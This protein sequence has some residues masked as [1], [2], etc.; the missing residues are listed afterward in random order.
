MKAF[1]GDAIKQAGVSI[2]VDDDAVLEAVPECSAVGESA[3]NGKAERAAQMLEDQVRNR[4]SALEARINARVNAEHPAMRWLVRQ[5]ALIL[6]RFS[7]NPNVQTPYQTLHEKHASDTCVEF[8]TKVYYSVP[9]HMTYKLELRWRLGICI[10][11]SNGTNEYYAALSNGNV[12][13]ARS[14]VRV[15]ASRRCSA[16]SVHEYRRHPRRY[17]CQ[18]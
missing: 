8:G 1:V 3:S 2:L 5:A 14:I 15:I 12:V 9:K 11:H 6:N 18:W 16:D 17:S 13:K 7:V 4:K 10:G